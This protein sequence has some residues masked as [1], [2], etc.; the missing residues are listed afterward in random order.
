[1]MRTRD[2]SGSMP[3]SASR[4]LHSTGGSSQ[5]SEYPNFWLPSLSSSSSEDPEG[6][7][8]CA[9]LLASLQ[10]KSQ[11]PPEDIPRERPAPLS[12]RDPNLVVRIATPIDVRSEPPDTRLLMCNQ[13]T[14][15]NIMGGTVL[16]KEIVDWLCQQLKVSSAEAWDK[17]IAIPCNAAGELTSMGSNLH[18]DGTCNPCAYW[19][20]G[21]CSHSILCRHCHLFHEGQKSKRL[22][23][24]KQRRQKMRQ[25][26]K[27]GED[28]ASAAADGPP[29]DADEDGHS[30]AQ[31][32]QQARGQG[33]TKISL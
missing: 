24:S 25:R 2:V 26:M 7:A 3:A 12:S 22:R 31:G 16:A 29:S 21:V 4:G 28:S 32:H 9:Q 17:L 11:P 13:S 19:F 15:K 20:K 18:T 27:N 8:R 10:S 23:P 6:N 30:A 5:S 1:M 14:P 33:K